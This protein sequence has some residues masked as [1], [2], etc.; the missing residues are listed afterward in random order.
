V[1]YHYSVLDAYCGPLANENYI[2]F[3]FK[4]GAA[5]ETRRIRRV[6][7]IAG[8]LR[9]LDFS[10]E[11][12]GDRVAASFRK[13]ELAEVTSRLDQLG[14]LLQFTRQMDMLMTSEDSVQHLARAFLSGNYCHDPDHPGQE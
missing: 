5:D 7:A 3:S 10:V 1:G 9:A 12:V 14:R 8:I 11:V 2:S 6:R 13:D 4:G